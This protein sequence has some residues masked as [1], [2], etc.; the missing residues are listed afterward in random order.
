MQGNLT[1]GRDFPRTY[2]EFVERF[3]G[4]AACAGGPSRVSASNNGSHLA[5]L[6]ARQQDNVVK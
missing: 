6:G 3:P 5:G 4:D 1:I 2:R